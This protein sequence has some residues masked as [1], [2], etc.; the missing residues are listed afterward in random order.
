M[1]HP[2]IDGPDQVVGMTQ[3]YAYRL[4]KDI[5]WSGR[6]QIVPAYHHTPKGGSGG[7]A[8]RIPLLPGCLWSRGAFRKDE[9]LLMMLDKDKRCYM[10][11]DK[12]I[13]LKI[14]KRH[15]SI[16]KAAD[17]LRD[18]MRQPEPN[19]AALLKQ[20]RSADTDD[21][22]AHRMALQLQE[23]TN[24]QMFYRL[25]AHF[26]NY[27][28][29]VEKWKNEEDRDGEKLQYYMSLY[30]SVVQP[31]S[32]D[33]ILN[34]LKQKIPVPA[35]YAFFEDLSSRLAGKT[36]GDSIVLIGPDS[37]TLDLVIDA[38]REA[39]N[40]ETVVFDLRSFNSSTAV[41]GTPTD[42]LHASE[43]ILIKRLSTAV[44]DA[45]QMMV[46]C[47][48]IDALP[49]A[50]AASDMD[51]SVK[52]AVAPFLTERKIESPFLDDVPIDLTASL[53]ICTAASRK[54]CDQSILEQ[55]KAY[56]LPEI[57]CET[58]ATLLAPCLAEEAKEHGLP[59]D[60]LSEQTLLSVVMTYRSDFGLVSGRGLISD[61][62]SAAE[63]QPDRRI[64]PEAAAELLEATVDLEDPIVFANRHRALYTAGVMED[65]RALATQRKSRAEHDDRQQMLIHQKLEVLPFLIPTP[66]RQCFSHENFR[67]EVSALIG[68]EEEKEKLEMLLLGH[69]HIILDG[70]PGTGKT[71]L[72]RAAAKAKGLE[73]IELKLAGVSSQQLSGLPDYVH[74]AHWGMVA[75]A[76][77][78]A[79]STNV[80]VFGDELDKMIP[81]EGEA[82]AGSFWLGPLD[83][84]RAR[85]S[86]GFTDHFYGATEI[87]LGEQFEAIF[88]VNDLSAVSAPLRS[89]C[90]VIQ[91]NGYT[92]LEKMRIVTEAFLPAAEKERGCKISISDAAAAALVRNSVLNEAGVRGLRQ[93]FE[94]VVT[95]CGSRTGKD[96]IRI[97]EEDVTACFPK[98]PYI[99]LAEKGIPGCVNGL[100]VNHAGAG[101]V[102]PISC[103]RLNS[104]ERRITGLPQDDIRDSVTIAE[105]WVNRLGYATDST[106]FHFHFTPGGVPK[107]GPSAGV[108]IAVAMLSGMCGQPTDP[109]IAFTGEFDGFTIHPVG[110]IR[111]KLSA[112]S[113]SGLHTVVIPEA[114]RADLPGQN[115]FPGLRIRFAS[116]IDDVIKIVLPNLTLK[117]Y[118]FAG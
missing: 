37:I 40:R 99:Y 91:V 16:I 39:L 67:R 20:A 53:V 97:S 96:P 114:N 81:S 102:M 74:G 92:P 63:S 36:K 2:Y 61:L 51:H 52:T 33:V 14:E 77:A 113:V 68:L 59:D 65:I 29:E 109:G 58:A 38:L 55:C 54:L 73:C 90:R 62:A 101:L 9:L 85:G 64:S 117:N 82:A 7:E 48:N 116:T 42:Y 108:A 86:R 25:S 5:Q 88:S 56:E 17:W 26:R 32:K 89:R 21:K 80:V 57:T 70:P 95:F 4:G 49:S 118:S 105:T 104:A 79:R 84:S 47:K 10:L 83:D 46:I 100:A 50:E 75:E 110:G 76:L 23:Q 22:P 72:A 45:A 27:P 111:E 12:A 44:G 93:D 60:W 30:S 19:Q 69:E 18:V 87:R 107:A 43:G 78:K 98:Q 112:A 6:E 34:T 66:A 31:V 1:M 41:L 28:A 11:L 8:E 3:P 15:G 71:S 13:Y 35:L 24:R 103:M 115:Q 106:G 94:Y